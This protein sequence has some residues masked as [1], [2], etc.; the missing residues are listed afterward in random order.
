MIYQQFFVNRS[1]NTSADTLLAIGWAALLQDISRVLGKPDK[2]ITLQFQNGSYAVTL[3]R[4]LHE[5]QLVSDTWL[6]FLDP[7][8]SAKQDERQAKKGRVL[9]NGFNYDEQREKQKLM[10]AQRKLLD[11]RLRSPDAFWTQDPA[12]TKLRQD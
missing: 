12:L 11:P 8:I 5:E 6:P 1:A 7:L 9:Q 3:S 10:V 2:H 4:G